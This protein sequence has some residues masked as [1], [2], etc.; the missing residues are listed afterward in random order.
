M[1]GTRWKRFFFSLLLSSYLFLKKNLTLSWFSRRVI[2]SWQ[3]LRAVWRSSGPPIVSKSGELGSGMGLSKS[4]RSVFN[5]KILA[6][7]S[8]RRDSGIAPS[9]TS[10]TRWCQKVGW[11][12]K[13]KNC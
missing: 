3:I 2:D 6:T 12:K 13:K 11:K 10:S 1:E 5:C 4:P 7:L 9:L 8:S